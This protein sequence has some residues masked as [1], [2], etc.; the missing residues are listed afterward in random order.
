MPCTASPLTTVRCHVCE[1]WPC[2]P[3][4][5]RS[6]V[7]GVQPRVIDILP[8]ATA[9]VHGTVVTTPQSYAHSVHVR[10]APASLTFEAL[11][12]SYSPHDIWP[13]PTAYAKATGI[14]KQSISGWGAPAN[15]TPLSS[16]REYNLTGTVSGV[17]VKPPCTA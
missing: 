15:A 8:L 5:Q 6:G 2:L 7:C 13:P 16:G 3:S 14:Y 4:L 10:L 12:H 9:D 1:P 11:K 17:S